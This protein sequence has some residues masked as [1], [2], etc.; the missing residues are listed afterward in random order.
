MATTPARAAGSRILTLEYD[1]PGS[2]W[3]SVARSPLL[4]AEEPSDEACRLLDE[5][6][7]GSCLH[8]AAMAYNAYVEFALVCARGI[9]QLE[10]TRALEEEEVRP[11]QLK[12]HLGCNMHTA[13]DMQLVGMKAKGKADGWAVLACLHASCELARLCLCYLC[14]AVYDCTRCGLA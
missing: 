5:V 10:L 7:A 4:Q 1:A 3:R 12:H 11:Q 8:D 9:T 6:A 2:P 14:C 13:H